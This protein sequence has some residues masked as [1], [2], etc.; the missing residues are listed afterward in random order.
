[1]YDRLYRIIVGAQYICDVRRRDDDGY[2]GTYVQT[3]LCLL[4]QYGPMRLPSQT[5]FGVDSM[6]L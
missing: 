2:L 6:D 1:M 4:C 3:F 5:L